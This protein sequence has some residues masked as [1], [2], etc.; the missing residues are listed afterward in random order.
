M[1][2]SDSS[3]DVVLERLAA[4]FVER[5]RRGEHPPLS[6][7]TRRYPDLA[8]DIRELFPALVKIEKLK[9]PADA[10]GEFAAGAADRLR[11]ERLGDYR[12]LREVGRG[13]MGVVYEA[14]Q[15]SLGRHVAL[16]VLPSSA[17]LNPTYLARFRREAKAAGRLHHTNIVPVFGVGEADGVPFYAMQFIKGEGLDKVLADVRRLRRPPGAG[18]AAPPSEGS[19]AQSLLSGRFNLPAG[20][21]DLLSV[22]QANEHADTSSAT[23]RL[24]VGGPEAEYY[25]GVAR[26]GVQVADAL[27]YA[28]RQGILH[29]D[30]KP[31]NLLLD[32]QGMV[33]VTDFG[34]A[35]AEGAEELTQTGDIVGTIRFMAPE[36]FEGKSLPQSDVYA[37]GLTLYEMLTLRPAFDDTNKGRLIDRVLHEPPQPPRKLD[38]RIPRDVETVVLKCLAK[39][40]KERYATAE[41]LAEDPR[42]F[43]ADRPIHARRTTAAE[44]TWRWCRRNPWLAGLSAAVMLLL[45]VVAV[46]SSVFALRLQEE[47]GHRRLAERDQ[48]EKLFTAQVAEARARRYSGR[49]GQRFKSLDAIRQAIELARRLEK[50]PETFD[51]L[52]NEAIAALCL[53]D[54]DD[55]GL[56]WKTA[57]P[58]CPIGF[59]ANAQRYVQLDRKGH[60]FVCR[61]VEDK[62]V[63]LA[64]LE[65]SGGAVGE[66]YSPDLRFLALTSPPPPGTPWIEGKGY[67]W[68]KLWRCDG[69]SAKLVLE[70]PAGVW[71]QGPV[72]RPDG[73]QLAIGHPDG[74]LAVYDTETGAAVRRWLVGSAGLAAFNPRLPRL[75]VAC[76]A[77]VRCYDIETGALLPPRFNNPGGISSVA[78]H[79]DDRRLAIGCYGAKIVLW[80][81]E[82]GRQL[83]PPWEGCTNSGIHLRFNATGDRLL[84][85]DWTQILRLWDAGTGRQ[86]FDMPDW[87]QP[88]LGFYRSDQ[89]IGRYPEDS[90]KLLRF[91]PGREHQVLVSNTPGRVEEGCEHFW[92]PRGWL[93]SADLPIDGRFGFDSSGDLLSANANGVFRW[94]VH[95]EPGQPEK[96]HLGPPRRVSPQHALRGAESDSSL[97][98]AVMAF[99]HGTHTT[100]VH[101]GPPFRT[102][103]LGPQYDVRHAAVSPDGRWVVTGSHFPAGYG[104]DAKVWEVATG[105]LVKVLPINSNS[106]PAFSRDG[107]WLHTQRGSGYWCQ[108]G[109]WEP[110]P[111]SC[112]PGVLS[113]DGRLLACAA[114]YGEIRLVNFASAKEIA[115]LSIPDQTRLAPAYFSPDGAWLYANGIESNQLHRW[116]LRLIRSQLAE[117]GLDMDLPAHPEPPARPMSWP[118]PAVTVHHPELASDAGKLRQWELTQAALAWRANPFDP[119]AHARLGALARADGR[120]GDAFAHLSIAR[121]LRPDDFEVRRL[122]ALAARQCGQWA[123]AVTDATWVLHEQPGHLHA[124]LAR[125]ESLQRLGRHAEAV[126][127]LTALLKFYPRDANLYE[128]RARSYDAL[129]DRDHADADREK[130]AEVAPRD[131]SRINARA[132]HFLTGPA[133]QRDP[134]LALEL[135]I[136]AVERA[137]DT[138]EYLNTLG[139]AQ[140]RNGL[141]REAIATLEKSLEAGKGQ[142]DGFDLF[143][144]AMCHARLGNAAKARDCYDRAVKWGGGQKNLPPQHK[145]ELQAFRA[146]AEEVLRNERPAR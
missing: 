105:R 92:H 53:P 37:L 45:L 63:R 39:D 127:D 73:R 139:V 84:S 123:D 109:T 33:W 91:A 23:S 100:V 77:E 30:V 57:C 74:T 143:F 32:L 145:E 62:E 135:A 121:A 101:Q 1:P 112:P 126:E 128:Q 55:G 67:E 2:S 79:P 56:E 59:D 17:L 117:L 118:P 90:I 114:G 86:L 58:S 35:K 141:Y 130:A 61:V 70:D 8:A 94:P 72:F 80:D 29:R 28:H 107:R 69:P 49:S 122:R 104:E 10:T 115:R 5:H 146:E 140:Y 71:E 44:K 106:G 64:E 60:A 12:I 38:P 133:D 47:L 85:M 102:L 15:E 81:S 50:P 96:Y 21:T 26:I 95:V 76:G 110:K 43:L 19:V 78:W 13:G 4:E 134:I 36:R 138:Q 131:V 68:V 142:F 7:Y 75:A 144:L 11:P 97:A 16:K 25:R 124:L 125:G 51:E 14:E 93:L 88:V 9:P 136:K 20:E 66:W 3:R 18:E 31:S 22:P 98:G 65:V 6:E 103:T 120:S 89:F 24:S 42:R 99:A 108:V 52:R 27:A 116:D 82:T 113:P 41:A 87:G 137:P 119:D 132:W 34:L 54:I 111:V 46:G 83:T 129:K 48:L 40:P